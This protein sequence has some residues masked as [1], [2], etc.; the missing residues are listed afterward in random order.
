MS[1]PIPG[2]AKA[3]VFNQK[4]KYLPLEAQGATLHNDAVQRGLV[5]QLTFVPSLPTSLLLF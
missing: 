2:V 3:L 1:D 5:A 4:M